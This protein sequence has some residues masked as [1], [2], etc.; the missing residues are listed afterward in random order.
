[1][2]V[3]FYDSVIF[4]LTTIIL[5]EPEPDILDYWANIFGRKKKF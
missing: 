3:V 2:K 4:F 1:M 5:I